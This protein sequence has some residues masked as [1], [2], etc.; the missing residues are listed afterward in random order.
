MNQTPYIQTDR[1][2]LP[3]W[4]GGY[5]KGLDE[6]RAKLDMENFDTY[7]DYNKAVEKSAS[8]RADFTVEN[9]QGSGMTKD[10]PAIMREQGKVYEIFTMFYTFF[11]SLWNQSR[12]MVRGVKRDIADENVSFIN[13]TTSLA[14]KLMFM[15]AVPVA[16]ET[17]LRQGFGDEEDD[18]GDWLTNYAVSLAL[19]PLQT[20]PLVRDAANALGEGFRFQ[21]TPLQK[22]IESG[23][24][25]TRQVIKGVFTDDEITK[26]SVKNTTKLIGAILK[27][28]GVSQAWITGEELYDV[29]IEGDD[30][31]FRELILGPK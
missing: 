21:L 6:A 13:S 28:P 10:L 18:L 29:I 30:L 31:S 1:G 25:G 17:L 9:T 22:L 12:D 11:A 7:E 14:A 15:Y 8:A 19:Y 4:Y 24:S 27:V 2:D 20:V 23:L 26:T 3:T 5:Y 16:Y